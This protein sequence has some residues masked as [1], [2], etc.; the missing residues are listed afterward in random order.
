MLNENKSKIV[1]TCCWR[2]MNTFLGKIK[3]EIR[4][5]NAIRTKLIR[6]E[7]QKSS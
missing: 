4:R 2:K 3:S 1:N 7:Q 5:L 6:M